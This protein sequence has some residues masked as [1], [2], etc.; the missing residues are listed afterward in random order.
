MPLVLN[1]KRKGYGGSSGAHSLGR[2][3]KWPVEKKKKKVA[4]WH[5]ADKDWK[6]RAMYTVAEQG[7]ISEEQPIWVIPNFRV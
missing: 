1:N 7:G 4:C 3:K 5:S 6:G 2:D